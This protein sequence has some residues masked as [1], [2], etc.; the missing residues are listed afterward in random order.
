MFLYYAGVVQ[1]LD[2]IAMVIEILD[3]ILRPYQYCYSPK[4]ELLLEPFRFTAT[5]MA[6]EMASKI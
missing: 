4:L 6:C 5:L 3:F 1:Y 2:F